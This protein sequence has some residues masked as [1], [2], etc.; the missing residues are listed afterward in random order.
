MVCRDICNPISIIKTVFFLVSLE[1]E[2]LKNMA[3]IT[4]RDTGIGMPRDLMRLL[5]DP[6]AKTSRRGTNNEEGTGFGMPLVKT[7]LAMFG[8]NIHIESVEQQPGTMQDGTRVEIR[9]PIAESD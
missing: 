8:G 5:F 4:I 1:A 3:L 9:L 7:F 6:Q 2:R